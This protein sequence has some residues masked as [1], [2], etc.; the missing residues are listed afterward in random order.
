MAVK[1]GINLDKGRREVQADWGKMS[2]GWKLAKQ[3]S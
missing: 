2:D 3:N 1:K